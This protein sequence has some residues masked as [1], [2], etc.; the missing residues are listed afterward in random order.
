M[1]MPAF[2]STAGSPYSSRSCWPACL[3]KARACAKTS[4]GRCDMA[5]GVKLDDLLHDRRMTLTEL[6]DRIG[7]ALAN[8]RSEEHTSE[9][10]SQS[11]LVCRLL[12]EKKNRPISHSRL[13]RPR[14]RALAASDSRPTTS[15]PVDDPPEPVCHPATQNFTHN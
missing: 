1:S 7:M 10:Q 6:A 12:L 3:R 9:L 15:P 5:I 4:T 13:V 8:L 11:N 2:R 14:S